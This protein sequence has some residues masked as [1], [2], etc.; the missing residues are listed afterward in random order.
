MMEGTP[1]RRTV[2]PS[3]SPASWAWPGRSSTPSRPAGAWGS[4]IAGLEEGLHQGPRGVAPADPG[5]EVHRL[6]PPTVSSTAASSQ[7]VTRP[8]GAVACT[9]VR[10]PGRAHHPDHA[11]AGAAGRW[12]P[13]GRSRT[14]SAQGA[15]AGVRRPERVGLAGTPALDSRQRSIAGG[16][17]PLGPV[18]RVRV[19]DPAGFCPRCSGAGTVDGP[20]GLG[21]GQFEGLKLLSGAGAEVGLRRGTLRDLQRCHHVPAM[22]SHLHAV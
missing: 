22:S 4:S 1:F 11:G 20:R 16:G 6:R 19:L 2:V 14:G 17:T 3:C 12:R 5:T 8:S 13:R 21:W 15:G 9:A 10:L 7:G 18:R